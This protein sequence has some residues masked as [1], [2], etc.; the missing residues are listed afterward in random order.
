MNNVAL[1][2]LIT[3]LCVRSP[4]LIHYKTKGRSVFFDYMSM[5]MIYRFK[6]LY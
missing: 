4:E 3:M 5:V 6:Y 2:P 1:I